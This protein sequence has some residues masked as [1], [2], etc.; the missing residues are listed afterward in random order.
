MSLRAIFIKHTLHFRFEAGTSR[1]VLTQKDS[2]FIKIYDHQQPEL[3]GLGECAPLKGLSLD[4]R[5]D[6]EMR[7]LHICENFNNL[8]LEVFSWNLGIILEQVI[9][10]EF[11]SVV[12]GFEM[13]L[14]DYMNGGR[15]MV[16]DNA[17]SRSERSIEINGLVW[18]GNKQQMI[19]QIDEKLEA[20]YNTLKLK[21][22]ALRFEQEL[23][24]LEHIRQRFSP[25]QIVIRVDA[26]GAFS[27]S[28]VY[29]KLHQLAEF[30]LHSIEQPIKAGQ[31]EIMAELCQDTPL[32]IALDEEL[33]GYQDYMDKFKLLKT[34]NPQYIVLK[35]TL[36]GGFLQSRQWIEIANRLK[37]GWWITSA[38][39]SNVG[40]SA[41]AQFTA[42]FNNSLP[43]GLGTGQ[44]YHNNI[45]GPLSI[46]Q[47]KIQYLEGQPWHY[48]YL[49]E[50]L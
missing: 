25:E 7:L 5:P 2:Y 30:S 50:I 45:E 17:F 24:C 49:R 34:I 10:P 36:L 4:Y 13:A 22:G 27:V 11:P 33:I 21:I 8:D 26:N 37:I 42:E 15:R 32:P 35:P 23:A 14:L 12:F 39:E 3:F 47:G 44:L 46:S 1:G 6:F 31:H 41:I 20:G 38:L 43:Q 16:F 18:M 40:L 29:Q 28:E 19:A 48:E 9:D